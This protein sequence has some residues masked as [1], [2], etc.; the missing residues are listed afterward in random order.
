MA[1]ITARADDRIAKIAGVELKYDLI[2]G[3]TECNRMEDLAR[4]GSDQSPELIQREREHCEASAAA[5]AYM[6]ASLR[7]SSLK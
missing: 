7:G 4:V 1:D 2:S 5:L 3:L 6:W